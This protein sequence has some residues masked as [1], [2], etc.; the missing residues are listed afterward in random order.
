MNYYVESQFST[1]FFFEDSEESYLDHKIL[2]TLPY[3]IDCSLDYKHS[4]S[5][6]EESSYL[7]ELSL[8]K[9]KKHNSLIYRDKD[10]MSQEELED[11]SLYYYTE[12]TL[13]YK[14][15]TNDEYEKYFDVINVY[16][17]L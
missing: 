6:I 4:L 12:T 8:Y 15:I 5:T 2:V 3:E 11:M 1:I 14:Q 16:N 17:S 10:Y 9:K 13:S 7:N